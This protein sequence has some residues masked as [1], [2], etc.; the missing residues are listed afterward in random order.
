[1]E[2]QLP[3]RLIPTPPSVVL[4]TN[5]SFGEKKWMT[6]ASFGAQEKDD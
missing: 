2:E 6:L 1:M 4:G 3:I 5:E